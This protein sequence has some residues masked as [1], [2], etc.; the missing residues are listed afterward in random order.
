MG[1]Y[2]CYLFIYAVRTYTLLIKFHN[3]LILGK[4]SVQLE[5]KQL[6]QK[7]KLLSSLL[8]TNKVKSIEAK[9][10]GLEEVDHKVYLTQPSITSRYLI[11]ILLLVYFL[12]TQEY[13]V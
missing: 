10:C 12:I 11:F 9:L 3:N 8:N 2:K 1:V 4:V 6:V 7:K 5:I 13:K